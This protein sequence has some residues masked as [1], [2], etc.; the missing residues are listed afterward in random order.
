MKTRTFTV[1]AKAL[2]FANFESDEIASDVRK[3]FEAVDLELDEAGYEETTSI[4]ESID[5][6]VESIKEHE[7]EIAQEDDEDDEDED[8]DA[9][10]DDEDEDDE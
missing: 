10:F 7:A 5:S 4:D 1:L 2:S 8:E 3:V 6:L 9:E